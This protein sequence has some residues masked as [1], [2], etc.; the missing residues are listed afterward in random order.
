MEEIIRE[1]FVAYNLRKK[2]EF[3]P[4]RVRTVSYRIETIKYRGQHLWIRPRPNALNFSILLSQQRMVLP[5]TYELLGYNINVN[6]CS[7]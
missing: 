4:P 6:L 3:F 7:Q 2:N 5:G 1:R